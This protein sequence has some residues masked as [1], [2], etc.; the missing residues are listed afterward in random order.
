MDD[1]FEHALF[2]IY[3]PE[4]DLQKMRQLQ[5]RNHRQFPS[6]HGIE[7][8]ILDSTSSPSHREEVIDETK[9]IIQNLD[10]LN[11]LY[12]STKKKKNFS[13]STKLKKLPNTPLLQNYKF[14]DTSIK[15]DDKGFRVINN[16][17]DFIS[18]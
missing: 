12:I 16:A 10:S 11:K 8:I 5:S 6:M 1:D 9:D 7:H 4:I 3:E 15:A 2:E 17:E 18:K 13:I 14:R